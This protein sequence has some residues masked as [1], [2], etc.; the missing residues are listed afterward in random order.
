MDKI[1][2]TSNSPFTGCTTIA[3]ILKEDYMYEHVNMSDILINMYASE[4]QENG[5]N[6]STTDILKAKEFHRN[7][8]FQ[9]QVNNAEYFIQQVCEQILKC[10]NPTIVVEK[11]RTNKQAQALRTLGFTLIRIDRPIENIR[12]VAR[13]KGHTDETWAAL[14]RSGSEGRVTDDQISEFLVNTF[15]ASSLA[16]YLVQA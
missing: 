3:R 7:G 11:V 14:M 13:R 1:A 8:L 12:A 9:Y 10:K 16:K 15:T 4:L 5:Y 6:Y 2:L